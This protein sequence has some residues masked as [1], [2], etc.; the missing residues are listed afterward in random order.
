LSA[1]PEPTEDAELVRLLAV[2]CNHAYAFGA[3]TNGQLRRA[4]FARE[5]VARAALLDYIAAHY[6]RRDRL[7]PDEWDNLDAT[8][9]LGWEP[10][11][12]EQA[13]GGDYTRQRG[14]RAARGILPWQ[15]GDVL[16]EERI[17]RVPSDGA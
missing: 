14:Y 6:V 2:C 9:P 17:R 4:A 12:I 16:P 10:V 15:P 5:E 3:A 7:V 11:E 8:A 1:S 13:D